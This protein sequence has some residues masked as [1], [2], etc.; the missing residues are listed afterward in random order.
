[1][2]GDATRTAIAV[3]H[4]AAAHHALP[5]EQRRGREE[6][7]GEHRR[8]SVH[9]REVDEVVDDAHPRPKAGENG[10]HHAVR[11][12]PPDHHGAEGRQREQ[13]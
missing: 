3:E 9:R 8:G 13:E 5:R 12:A 6:H 4:Q 2:A 10:A 1:V 7:R 11:R